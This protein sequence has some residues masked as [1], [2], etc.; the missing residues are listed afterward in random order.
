MNSRIRDV[1]SPNLWISS[2]LDEKKF[3]AERHSDRL[4]DWNSSLDWKTWNGKNYWFAIMKKDIQSNWKYSHLEPSINIFSLFWRK[5]RVKV[6]KRQKISHLQI[7][8]Y[9][10]SHCLDL[11]MNGLLTRRNFWHILGMLGH[12]AIPKWKEFLKSREPIL[13]KSYLSTFVLV[14]RPFRTRSKQCVL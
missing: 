3:F 2:I 5:L 14:K 7:D 10:H 12:Y 11:D 6:F 8:V 1:C 4:T 9:C 13:R